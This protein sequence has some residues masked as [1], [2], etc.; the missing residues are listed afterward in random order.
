MI[1]VVVLSVRIRLDVGFGSSV[2]FCVV[3]PIKT[4]LAGIKT[5]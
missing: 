1:I 4:K 5:K 2:N 3:K